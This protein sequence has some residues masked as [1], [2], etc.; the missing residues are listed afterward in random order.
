MLKKLIN[1]FIHAFRG[2]GIAAKSERNFRIHII[3]A[4]IV[5]SAAIYFKI[6]QSEWIAI[7]GC[8]GFVIAAELF[9]T[10]I[11]E[12]CNKTHPERDSLIGKVKDLAAAGVLIA[13]LTS[14]LVGVLVFGKYL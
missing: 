11:E 4:C 3:A 1:S 14:M 9:N 5:V 6:S 13:A 2:I 7:L 12:L 10:A 8:I